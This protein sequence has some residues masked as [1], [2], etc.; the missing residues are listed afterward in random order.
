MKINIWDK[1]DYFLY[2]DHWTRSGHSN[3]LNIRKKILST[4]LSNLEKDNI[5]IFLDKKSVFNFL[6][7][8]EYNLEAEAEYLSIYRE[9]KNIVLDVIRKNNYRIIYQDTNQVKIYI[10]KRLIIIRFIKKQFFNPKLIKIEVLDC[11]IYFF[12]QYFFQ[13]YLLQKYIQKNKAILHR[14]ISKYFTFLKRM[15]QNKL[16][17]DMNIRD[18]EYD[19]IYKIGLKTFLNL[20]I[21]H[22]N[23]PSWIVR[24]SHLDIVTN[25]KKNLK[26]KDI[27]NYLSN[28]DS[29]N[30]LMKRVEI[31]QL[32]D[33]IS[34]SISHSKYFWSSGNNFF[35]F[36]VYYQFRKGVVP[37]KEANEYIKNKNKINLYSREYFEQLEPMN[38]IEIT[39]FLKDNLIEITDN[40]ISSGKHRVFAMIGR[41]VE[42]KEYIPFYG[43]IY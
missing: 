24:K 21:E 31:T 12:R 34:G 35:L 8:N 5:S 6:H 42:G 40:H 43:R 20:N 38:D 9:S 27:V 22:K 25:N 3:S 28:E 32:D 14:I 13:Y 33:L 17:R 2:Y 30:S 37:Y 29:L 1:L 10:D 16:K 7:H 36:S 18:I 23:S 41:L 15:N 26:V 19:K 4:L 11:E 39:S